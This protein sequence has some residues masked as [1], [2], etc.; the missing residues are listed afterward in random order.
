MEVNTENKLAA[1]LLALHS[2]SPLVILHR[3]NFCT[4]DARL[5]HENNIIH[6]HWQQ[7]DT[8]GVH[9]CGLCI[10]GER[11]K[12]VVV[13]GNKIKLVGEFEHT[14]DSKLQDTV[15]PFPEF[16]VMRLDDYTDLEERYNELYKG[17]I[18][19]M[20]RLNNICLH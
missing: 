16:C 1:L 5:Y 17:Y 9:T 3:G 12:D 2:D 11:L 8:D 6:I 20:N 18:R 7:P 13:A 10:A 4:V 19:T 14:K 15:I